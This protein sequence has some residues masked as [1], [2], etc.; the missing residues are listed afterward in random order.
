MIKKWLKQTKNEKG[1]TLVELLAVVVILGIIAA[2]AVPSIGGIIDNSKKD[3]AIS[4]AQQVLSAA[5][6]YA[7]SGGDTSGTIDY[8]SGNGAIAEYHEPITNPWGE[9]SVT[10]TVAFG[11]S[12]DTVPEINM[13]FTN[14]KCNI[15]YD[16]T[17]INRINATDLS[18]SSRDEACSE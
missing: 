8:N 1:L 10:Y 11:G 4:N 2:I 5:R 7:A 16:S 14:G 18:N 12:N 17:G 13:V 3:A 9:G 6:L 15:G